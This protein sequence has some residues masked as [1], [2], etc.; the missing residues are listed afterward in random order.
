VPKLALVQDGT[1]GARQRF[2]DVLSCYQRCCEDLSDGRFM[3]FELDVF[4]DERVASLIQNLDP[5][6]WGCVVFA[7]NALLSGAVEDAVLSHQERFHAYLRAGGGLV[8]L[9]QQRDDLAPLLPGDLLPEMHERTSPRGSTAVRP[10]PG[11]EADILLRWPADA[12]WNTLGD[13]DEYAVAAL[14]SEG[15]LIELPSLYFKAFAADSLPGGLQ[16][17]LLSSGGEVLAC[18]SLDHRPERVVLMTPP[19]DWPRL[20][21]PQQDAIRALLNN[22]IRYA[23]LGRPT[24]LVWYRADNPG[25]EL[26]LRWLNL[27]GHAAM[28][29]APAGDPPQIDAGDR[30]LLDSVDAFVLPL[31]RLPQFEHRLELTNY[32]ERGGTVIATE[33]ERQHHATQ[34]TALVGR[35]GERRLA[36]EIYAELRAVPGWRSVDHAFELRNIVSVLDLIDRDDV[37]RQTPA[38]I[39]PASLANLGLELRRRLVAPNHRE[40][41]G[42]SIALAHSLALIE[43]N[44]AP[45]P[46]NFI[47]WMGVDLDLRPFDVRLQITAVL[48]LARREPADGFI[49]AAIRECESNRDRMASPAPLVR[50]LDAI[51]ALD[52][53]ELL[54]IDDAGKDAARLGDL[55]AAKLVEFEQLPSGGWMSVEAT[56]EIT[57]GL[58][59]LYRHVPQDE[60]AIRKRIM[61]LVATGATALR[62][63][64]EHY[65]ANRKGVAWLARITEALILSDRDFPLGLERLTSLEWSARQMKRAGGRSDQALIEE[66]AVRNED[67]RRSTLASSERG[68]ALA[69][70]LA[71]QNLAAGVGRAT[72]S[73]IPA[74]VLLAAAIVVVIQIGW[75][76]LGGLL[77]NIAILAGVVLTILG[78]IFSLLSRWHL[79]A[80]PAMRIRDWA[81]ETGTPLLSQISG[82]KRG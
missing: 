73:L 21:P 11:A 46:G 78:W 6:E 52:H 63:A 66:L 34:V 23:S 28:H 36:S 69:K 31:T 3:Q 40:D 39:T 43:P 82:L 18:R 2:A 60:V 26:L 20:R 55:C 14:R 9:H 64:R 81:R 27:D 1:E 49:A 74:T 76:S 44:S 45:V 10:A 29:P 50:I 4:T 13:L 58:M 17:V 61:S 54:V 37:L 51:S 47:D 70:Q 59:A 56:A 67:L 12:D 57:L 33:T 80:G 19:L 5:D 35:H 62:R 32:L 77:A 48:A 16:P 71:E 38:A 79:L 30:W 8:V 65:R 7:S 24:R 25:N 72:A 22:S 41:L 53:R 42:S 15:H 75:G 68:D